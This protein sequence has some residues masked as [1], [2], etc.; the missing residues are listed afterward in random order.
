MAIASIR[1]GHQTNVYSMVCM[2][3]KDLNNREAGAR[4]SKA[5]R[6]GKRNGPNACGF[7]KLLRKDVNK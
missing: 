6:L 5:N 1:S 3:Q 7:N 2:E 4:A